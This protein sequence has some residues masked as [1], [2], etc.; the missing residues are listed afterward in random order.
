MRK[1]Q[2]VKPTTD[3]RKEVE[4]KSPSVKGMMIPLSKC[5]TVHE[6][7]NLYE[8]IVALD[9][10]QKAQKR[11]FYK[12]R[13]VLVLNRDG[14]VVGKIN[15]LDLIIGIED[16]YKKVGDLRSVSHTGFSREFITMMIE[17]NKLWHDPLEDL[18]RKAARHKVSNMMDKPTPGEYV[19]HEDSLVEAIHRLVLGHYPYL[20]VTKDEEVIGILRME[21]VFKLVC[22]QIKACG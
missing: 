9:N 22:D 12:V 10:I 13:G 17:R 4:M 1:P 21:D 2:S 3:R 5:A 6:D 19:D 14:R 20:L 15:P 11:D 8:A 18:C 16:N 7:S